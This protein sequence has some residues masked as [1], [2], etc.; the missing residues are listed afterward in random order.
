MLE[1]IDYVFYITGILTWAI[2]GYK[3]GGYFVNKL[4]EV[5]RKQKGVGFD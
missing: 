2:I 1:P 5:F 3:A 4:F